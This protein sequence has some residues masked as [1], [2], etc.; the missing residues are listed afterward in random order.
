MLLS[1]LIIFE[2]LKM[3]LLKTGDL[4]IA[5]CRFLYLTTLLV[6]LPEHE[7][8]SENERLIFCPTDELKMLLSSDSGQLMMSG[9]LLNCF[10]LG[11]L[12]FCERLVREI[13]NKSNNIAWGA[14][15]FMVPGRFYWIIGYNST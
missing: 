7:R 1:L 6:T 8:L 4:T 5:V 11:M 14:R 13:N 3:V 15:C 9:K 12:L 10:G 2:T